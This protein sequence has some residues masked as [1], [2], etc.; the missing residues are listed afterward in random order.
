[1]KSRAT[2]VT[3]SSLSQ[4]PYNNPRP[5]TFPRTT[6]THT[7]A[8]HN[9]AT[10]QPRRT[11]SDCLLPSALSISSSQ[12]RS[13]NTTRRMGQPT[14][15]VQ[16]SPATPASTKTLNGVNGHSTPSG[17]KYASSVAYATMNS[18]STPQKLASDS[19]NSTT[20]A[21]TNPEDRTLIMGISFFPFPRQSTFLASGMDN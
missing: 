11:I 6:T 5:T 16:T 4:L 1:M 2:R 17:Q 7:T 20:A 19:S 18:A 21:S 3:K 12:I 15:G 8:F 9:L 13:L 10:N 14:N